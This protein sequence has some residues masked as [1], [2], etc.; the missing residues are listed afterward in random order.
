MGGNKNIFRITDAFTKYAEICAIPTAET[1]VDM[2]FTKWMRRY[3]CPLIIHTDGGKEFINENNSRGKR[4]KNWKN[5]K[6]I[7]WIIKRI[8]NL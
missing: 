1:E 4:K 6:T 2:V 7:H 5:V 8:K 3:K